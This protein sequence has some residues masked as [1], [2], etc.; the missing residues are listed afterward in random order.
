MLVVEVFGIVVLSVY[1]NA[2]DD[3]WFHRVR[4]HCYPFATLFIVAKIRVR[5][6]RAHRRIWV[7]LG[8]WD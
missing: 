7:K 5:N 2:V 6:A 4:P 1:V 3:Y 8:K